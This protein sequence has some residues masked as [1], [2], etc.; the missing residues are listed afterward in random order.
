VDAGQPG[1]E[2]GVR[3]CEAASDHDLHR[4]ILSMDGTDAAPCVCIG[5]VR[6][7]APVEDEE[8]RIV[9][10]ADEFVARLEQ[11]ATKSIPFRLV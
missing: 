10:V 11:E 4:R 1:S 5:I 3:V 6:H 8:V 9:D 7:R 2:L